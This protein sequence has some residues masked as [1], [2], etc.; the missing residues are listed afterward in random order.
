MRNRS[1][2]IYAYVALAWENPWLQSLSCDA[3]NA[4]L[5]ERE[6][7]HRALLGD[8]GFWPLE[9]AGR[10][11]SRTRAS[12]RATAAARGDNGRTAA[13]QNST[14]APVPVPV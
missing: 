9:R 4:A 12:R 6:V 3:V 11:V 1:N 14:D 2:V 10:E 5:L 8:G 13:I 7:R